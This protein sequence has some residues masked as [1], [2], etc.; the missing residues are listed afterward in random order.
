MS[1][2]YFFDRNALI[3]PMSSHG[4]VSDLHIETNED[5]TTVLDTLTDIIQTHSLQTLILNG[6]TFNEFPY[7]QGVLN[8]IKAQSTRIV[9][10]EGNHESL[11][12][13]YQ[14]YTSYETYSFVDS[15]DGNPYN[16]YVTHGH[17][18][19]SI[20]DHIDSVILGHLHPED[21]GNPI[22]LEVGPYPKKIVLP[23]FRTQHSSVDY[24]KQ[25]THSPF[26]ETNTLPVTI[27]SNPNSKTEQ[28]P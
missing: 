26:F 10:I 27:H 15:K 28:Q 22:A 12:G 9:L 4:V 7:N 24:N 1:E 25:L 3:F 14:N 19:H 23:A 11:V 17:K 18:K 21:Q 2:P 5:V 16:V 13:G 6:D 20:P 8:W